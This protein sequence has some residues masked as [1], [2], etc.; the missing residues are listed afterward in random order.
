MATKKDEFMSLVKYLKKEDTNTEGVTA[1]AL[2]R[3]I[4][5]AIQG[6]TLSDM[7]PSTSKKEK[8][9]I[10]EGKISVGMPDEGYQSYRNDYLILDEDQFDSWY[11]GTY[12]PSLATSKGAT[13]P[14]ELTLAEIAAMDKEQREEYMRKIQEVKNKS[15]QATNTSL[16]KERE[17]EK[18]IKAGNLDKAKKVLDDWKPRNVDGL[19]MKSD[20]TDRHKAA[21]RKAAVVE[22]E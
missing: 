16:K 1:V 15:K 10:K 8:Y 19:T 5:A 7:F 13:A 21:V 12:L 9:T 3:A 6:G 17:F 20:L 18:L 2:D 11:T 14:K 4:S 22:E